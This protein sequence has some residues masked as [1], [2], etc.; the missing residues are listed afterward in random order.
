MIRAR[1]ASQD[2]PERSWVVPKVEYDSPPYAELRKRFDRVHPGYEGAHFAAVGACARVVPVSSSV[3]FRLLKSK[4]YTTGHE[5]LCA[6]E[7]RRIRASLY[8]EL[9][10]FA[11]NFPDEQLRNPIVALG[12]RCGGGNDRVA[13]LWAEGDA[14]LLDLA[15][16]NHV[17]GD[18]Y[19]FLAVSHVNPISP[20]SR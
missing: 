8:E 12:S 2:D 16:A 1:S 3:Y 9:I 6:M 7:S 13:V 10:E 14:R 4:R 17:W 18:F 11:W 5:A 19:R 15:P 20:L